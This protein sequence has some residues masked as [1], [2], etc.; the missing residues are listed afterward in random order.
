MLAVNSNDTPF[1]K[2]LSAE[3]S[4]KIPL[5]QIFFQKVRVLASPGGV[6]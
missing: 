4:I 3:Q 6:L 5:L 2:E 1:L